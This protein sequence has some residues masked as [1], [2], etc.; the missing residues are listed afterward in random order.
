M[1]LL[2]RCCASVF[3]QGFRHPPTDQIVTGSQRQP[4]DVLK[5]LAVCSR[6]HEVIQE[7]HWLFVGDDF[8]PSPVELF[9]FFAVEF[10]PSLLQQTIRF[11]ISE[12]KEICTSGCLAGI[13]R[14]ISVCIRKVT[15]REGESTG[16]ESMVLQALDHDA[17]LDDSFGHFNTGLAK[18]FCQNRRELLVDRTPCRTEE[19]K[20]ELYAILI[21]NAVTIMIFP[22]CLVEEFRR[23]LRIVR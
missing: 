8:L 5:S 2:G 22:S 11:G 18:Y 16:I 1:H 21:A 9:S 19:L 4:L 13:P 10:Q 23:F 7:C 14:L 3:L 6:F 20:L 15:M 12:I 17:K